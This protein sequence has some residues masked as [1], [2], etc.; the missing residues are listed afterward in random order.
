MSWRKNGRKLSRRKAIRDEARSRMHASRRNPEGSVTEYANSL[1]VY[2]W[3]R[4]KIRRFYD[5]APMTEWWP[6]LKKIEQ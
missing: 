4:D 5:I 3:A 6:I 1:D 2:L